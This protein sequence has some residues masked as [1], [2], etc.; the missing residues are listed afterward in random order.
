MPSTK[1]PKKRRVVVYL[2]HKV[3]GRLAWLEEQGFGNPSDILGAPI[4]EY[5]SKRFREERD[6]EDLEAGGQ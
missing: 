4:W 5:V 6:M 3:Y 2:P 1:S